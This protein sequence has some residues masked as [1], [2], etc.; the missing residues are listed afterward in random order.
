MREV[1]RKSDLVARLPHLG[2]HKA[3][4]LKLTSGVGHNLG[5]A[6]TCSF[7]LLGRAIG[8]DL[9][10]WHVTGGCSCPSIKFSAVFVYRRS[11]SV[12]Y[13]SEVTLLSLFRFTG[14]DW[15]V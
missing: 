14:C 5:M 2:E 4:L 9:A 6:L 15:R 12:V 7:G 11:G 10:V 13:L 1:I 8:H 3:T